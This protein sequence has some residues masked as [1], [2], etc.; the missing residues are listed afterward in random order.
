MKIITPEEV[1]AGL[2][3]RATERSW[4]DVRAENRRAT[5][6]IYDTVGGWFGTSASRLAD[7]ISA[8]DVDEI[9]VQINSP[10]GSVFEGIAIFNALRSHT[11][12]VVTR[13]DG[14]AASI[15]S[16][17]VQAGD[18]RRMMSGSQMMI[19]NA[20]G[21]VVGD[22][23]TLRKFADVLE[24]Q[25][26]VMAEIY[27]ERSGREAAAFLVDMD[28]ETWFKASDAVSAGLA[29][30]VVTTTPKTDDAETAS[31]DESEAAAARRHADDSVSLALLD[32]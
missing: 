23:D 31:T 2:N 11:A 10:G 12:R 22:A 26:D 30:V 25:N 4:F 18:E 14:L 9:E 20:W 8:L 3:A 32:L 17:I 29:D 24:Q 19:H 5:I 15:A 27:A 1:A 13:V 21:G 16:I 28:E 7:D 6:R